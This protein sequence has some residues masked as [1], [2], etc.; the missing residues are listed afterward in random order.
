MQRPDDSS[1]ATIL[2]VSFYPDPGTSAWRSENARLSPGTAFTDLVYFRLPE[3]LDPWTTRFVL[4][5][6]PSAAAAPGVEAPTLPASVPDGATAS[7]AFRIERDPGLH[8]RAF[9]HARR[10]KE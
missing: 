10:V 9:R 5:H 8:Q 6:V 7:A 2:S 3:D 1:V 4:A